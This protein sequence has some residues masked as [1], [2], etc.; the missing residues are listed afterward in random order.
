MNLVVERGPALSALSR[1][2]D[3]VLRKSTIPILGNLALSASGGSLRLRATD[4]EMEAS[5]TFPAD[6]Q[7]EGDITLPA[8][9]L[10]DIVSNADV[11]AQISLAQTDTRVTVR[12]GRSRFNLPALRADDFPSFKDDDFRPGFAVPARLL[13]DMISRVAWSADRNTDIY[14]CS[15]YLAAVGDEL[16]AV[17]ASNLGIALRREPK[18]EGAAFKAMLPPKLVSHL[19]K[20]LGDSAD[21]VT[22]SCT[23]SA[24]EDDGPARL[25]RFERP[26]SVLTSKLYDARAFVDYLL[27]FPDA[28]DCTAL[29]D[30]DA[31]A[32]GIRRVLVM[33]EDRVKPITLS[34][35]A[36]AISVTARGPDA[37]EGEDEIAADYS[38]PEEAF[39]VTATRASDAIGALRGDRIEIG[40]Q[41]DDGQT[42]SAKVLVRAPSD[43]GFVCIL[44]KLRG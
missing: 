2:S 7:T 1:L 29:T 33:A 9:K 20:W 25:I 22:V 18:P 34:F 21:D 41:P 12:S 37:L 4:L 3:I 31:L 36:G 19:I 13:A 24:Y 5:E 10:R 35:G 23:D 39:T 27:H 16:H 26:G 14:L 32:A 43:P 28:R 11:G 6:V 44:M 17:G 15:V 30:Q 38:G 42:D 40:F 8:D